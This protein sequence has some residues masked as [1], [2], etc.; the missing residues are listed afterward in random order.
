MRL[1]K[2]RDGIKV[3][4]FP[5]IRLLSKEEKKEMDCKCGDYKYCLNCKRE[6][7]GETKEN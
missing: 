7:Q 6:S 2:T 3:S 4:L 1:L 5:R